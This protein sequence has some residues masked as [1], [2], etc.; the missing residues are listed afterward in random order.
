MTKLKVGNKIVPVKALR[1]KS[2][3]IVIVEGTEYELRT[4]VT[5]E[6]EKHLKG[7]EVL[8]LFVER[9]SA[10]RVLDEDQ[11]AKYGWRKED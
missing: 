2:G 10:I 9:L 8:I 4:T 5:R 7:K 11:M 1:I 3:D 6:L